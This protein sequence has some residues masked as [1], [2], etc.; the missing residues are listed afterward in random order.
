[1][2]NKDGHKVVLYFSDLQNLINSLKKMKKEAENTVLQLETK[3]AERW[4]KKN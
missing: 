1:V 3:E 4:I 2:Q